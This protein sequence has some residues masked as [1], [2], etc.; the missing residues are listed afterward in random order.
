MP[1]N[2]TPKQHPEIPP[3][4]GLFNAISLACRAGKL[5]MGFDATVE[6]CMKGKAWLVLTTSDISPKTQKRMKETVEDILDVLPMPLTQT[7]M[8]MISKKPVAIY[9]IL[10]KNFAKLC[11]DKLELCGT[12]ATKEEMS[13]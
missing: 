12:L 3:Q 4:Q 6:A 1:K 10:D 8:L 9:A 5:T 2:K 13:E 11:Y 7:D